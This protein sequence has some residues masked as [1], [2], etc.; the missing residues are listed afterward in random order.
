MSE[1][2]PLSILCFG[3]SLVEGYTSSGAAYTPYSHALT[4]LLKERFPGRAIDTQ[5]D[6]KSGDLVTGGFEGRMRDRCKSN[7]SY[8]YQETSFLFSLLSRPRK[9]ARKKKSP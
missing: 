4:R 9:H 2:P 7:R 6:G 5:T 8:S 3:A 1:E